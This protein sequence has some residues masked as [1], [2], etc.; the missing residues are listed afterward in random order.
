MS[1]GVLPPW[2]AQAWKNA[3]N[4]WRGF[5]PH[6]TTVWRTLNIVAARCA[7][8]MLP[9]TIIVLAANDGGTQRPFCTVIVQR[10]FWPCQE[11]RKP[12]PVVVEALEDRAF[13]LVEIALLTIHLTADLHLT[14]V[15]GQVV[16]PG[17]KGR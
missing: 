7:L 11:D 13:R 2:V 3:L 12:T 16:L 17:D 8:Q 14:Q 4:Q 10:H 5:R 1:G 15:Y 6:N 9:G